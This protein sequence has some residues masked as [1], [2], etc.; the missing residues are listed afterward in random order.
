MSLQCIQI[1]ISIHTH[2]QTLAA[3][4]KQEFNGKESL[5]EK[6]CQYCKWLGY[7][8]QGNGVLALPTL[9]Y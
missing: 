6:S 5:K 4:R 7:K 9:G 3:A 1:F 8:T 2:T